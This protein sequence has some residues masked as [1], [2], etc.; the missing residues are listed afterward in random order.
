MIP[1]IEC[2]LFF[3]F[4]NVDIVSDNPVRSRITPCSHT[5]RIDP[6]LRR[7]NGMMVYEI[8]TS[9]N[10]LTQIGCEVWRYKLR[11]KTVPK[12][13]NNHFESSLSKWVSNDP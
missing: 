4:R 2:S 9:V 8:Y 1:S 13:H 5:A 6:G 12:K 3:Y 7:K 10:K 11:A